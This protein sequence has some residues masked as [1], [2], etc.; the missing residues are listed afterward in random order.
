MFPEHPSNVHHDPANDEWHRIAQDVSRMRER[1]AAAHRTHDLASADC[2][3]LIAPR[4]PVAAPG[5][6][7]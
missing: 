5:D 1:I 7:V 3:A 4:E 2:M 6:A